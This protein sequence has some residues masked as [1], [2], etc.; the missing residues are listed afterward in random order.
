MTSKNIFY[1]EDSL[2]ALYRA[3]GLADKI[4]LLHRRIETNHP[5]VERIAIALYD[6][7]TDLVKTL[8][9]CSEEP[10]PL[11][12]YEAKLSEAPSL[13]ETANLGRT[14]VVNDMQLFEEGSHE[15]TRKFE[16]SKYQASYTMPLYGEGRLLGFIFFNATESQAFTDALMTELD[17]IGHI[18]A[19]LLHSE[20]SKIHTLMATI[21]TAQQMAHKRDVETGA[22]L[23]RMAHYSHIIAKEL[24]VKYAFS[25]TFVENIYLYAPLHDIG[26]IGIADNILLKPGKL[27]DVEVSVMQRHTLIG[28]EMI[29]QLLDNYGLDGVEN[30]DMI[31]N[32]ALFHHESVDGSGYPEHRT[33]SDIPI[34]ARI[35]KVADIF[36]ALTS[37]RP[38][39]SAWE[40]DKAFSHLREMAG[41]KVDSD[42]VDALL[43]NTHQVENIQALY[44]ENRYG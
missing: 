9:Y 25:D 38:Y 11:A 29:D 12:H 15:H 18:A 10:T 44:A 7:T 8:L 41:S 35:V 28:K 6:A 17:L 24:A 33:G 21:K 32:I 3:G 2:A 1:H 31:R 37:S 16:H 30:V 40:N 39:K 34:E 36:D 42:C 26:K 43:K 5:E 4:K 27:T 23:E 13:R 14:R 22:H 20:I 19:M